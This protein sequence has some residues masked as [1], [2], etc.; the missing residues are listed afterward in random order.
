MLEKKNLVI[1][2]LKVL[3]FGRPKEQDYK[4]PLL[5]LV[6]HVGLR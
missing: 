1:P 4:E 6:D 2:A 3:I 5:L